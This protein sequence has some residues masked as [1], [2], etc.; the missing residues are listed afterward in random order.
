MGEVLGGLV[1]GVGRLFACW[2]C[3]RLQGQIECDV[4]QWADMV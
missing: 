2:D 3:C 1:H 4:A